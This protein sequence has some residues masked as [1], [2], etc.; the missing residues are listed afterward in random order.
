MKNSRDE[1]RAIR[2]ALDILEVLRLEKEP[3][4]LAYLHQALGLPK[5]TLARVLGTLEAAGF[6]E[7][8]STL[9]KFTLGMK[10]FYYGHAVSERITD[11]QVVAPVLKR[12]RD[13]CLETVYIYILH[14]NR[15]ICVDYLPGKNAVRVMTYVG[16]ESPLYVGA[17]GKVILAYFTDEEL[18]Q[19]FKETELVPHTPNTV[20]NRE[21]LMHEIKLIRQRGYAVSLGEKTA[22]VI[23]VSAPL[24]DEKGRVRSSL[25]IAAPLERQ[26][27]VDTYVKLVLEGAAEINSYR[28]IKYD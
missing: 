27:E 18:D 10:F 28:A 6:V 20:I 7:R 19:Y 12:I 9:Q 1:V 15:R 22:G 3:K 23:S 25:S 11:K 14:N 8:D 13:A 4:S 17:S 24:R 21:L 5:T 16:E 26:S 2:R